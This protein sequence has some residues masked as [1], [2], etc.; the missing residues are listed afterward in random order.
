[1]GVAGSLCTATTSSLVL[2]FLPATPSACTSIPSGKQLHSTSGCTTAVLSS[3]S[4]STSSSASTPIWVVSGNSPTAWACAL[5]SVLPTA[6]LSLLHL[7]SSSSTPSVR[8]RSLTPC[9][10]ASLEPSTTCWCS[11]L[12][13][14]S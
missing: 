1:M 6:L 10:W 11:R 4:F 9:P 14:T 3:S 13:T 2:L 12:S 5:G 7:Q 8:V